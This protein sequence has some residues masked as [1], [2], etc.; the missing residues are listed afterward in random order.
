[1]RSSNSPIFRYTF[2][3][4]FL[5]DSRPPSQF[6]AN[7][8]K[9]WN[10]DFCKTQGQKIK[11]ARYRIFKQGIVNRTKVAAPGSNDTDGYLIGVKGVFQQPARRSR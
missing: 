3:F 8:R 6:S 7:N 10:V 9:P 4:F 5:S 1:M 2:F 11:L